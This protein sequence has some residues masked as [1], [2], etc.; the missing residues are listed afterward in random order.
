MRIFKNLFLGAAS[1]SIF[2]LFGIIPVYGQPLG[3]MSPR[4]Q[5]ASRHECL[6][7]QAGRFVFGQISD[8]KKDQFMLDTHTGRLWRISESGMIGIFLSPVPYRNKEGKYSPLP[9]EITGETG[10]RPRRGMR[11]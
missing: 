7:S 8:S 3:I 6:S 2:V 5:E 10:N 11:K 4:A 1:A 9:E